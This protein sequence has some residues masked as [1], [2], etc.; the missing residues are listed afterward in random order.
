MARFRIVQRPSYRD[1]TRARF[2]I[3]ERVWW[4]WHYIT[5]RF[6]TEEAEQYILYIKNIRKNTVKT[7][8]IKECD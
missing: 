4:L 7:K 3:Y 6:T 2:E 5:F 1:P 8:V